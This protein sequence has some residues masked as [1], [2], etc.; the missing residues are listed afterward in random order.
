MDYLLGYNAVQSVESQPTWQ[1]E[2]AACLQSGFLLGLFFDPE[3]E[4]DVFRRNL[5]WVST[6][7][8]A[9]KT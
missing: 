1:S 9:V 4:C 8:T 6:E 7:Y 2:P 5:G 3:D